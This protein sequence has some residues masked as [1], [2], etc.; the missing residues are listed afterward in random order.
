MMY[1]EFIK[2]DDFVPP[3]ISLLL[4]VNLHGAT[5]MISFWGRSRVCLE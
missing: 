2:K 5:P 1:V 4:E 3:E